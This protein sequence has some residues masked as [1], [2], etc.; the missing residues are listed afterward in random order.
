ML[1][2]QEQVMILS[3]S[4]VVVLTLITQTAAGILGCCHFKTSTDPIY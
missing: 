4:F 2:R 1:F 3:L